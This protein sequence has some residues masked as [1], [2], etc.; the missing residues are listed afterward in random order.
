RKDAQACYLDAFGIFSRERRIDRVNKVREKLTQLDQW[1]SVEIPTTASTTLPLPIAA[2]EPITLPPAE[3]AHIPPSPF[4]KPR[5][6][7]QLPGTGTK[8]RISI[9]VVILLL[10]LAIIAAIALPL[11]LIRN[12][13]PSA[14]APTPHTFPRGIGVF[15]DEKNENIGISDGSYALDVGPD[16]AG[17]KDK[18]D[19]SAQLRAGNIGAATALWHS[20]LSQDSSDAEV[21]IYLEDQN[22]IASKQPYFTIVIGTVLSDNPVDYASRDQLQ[23][24]YVAQ[25]EYNEQAKRSGVPLL[26]LLIAKSGNN[27]T[28]SIPIAHQVVQAA[29]SDKT[30]IGVFG[31][32]KTNSSIDVLP[33]LADAH[34]P[35][36][37]SA[38]GGDDLSGRSPFFF[39][40]SPPNKVQAQVLVKYT[41][42]QL[43]P[44][45]LV[46]FV[47]P[48]DAF[49]QSFKEQRER[50]G[51]LCDSEVMT[52]LIHFHQSH[53]RHF[54][55]YYTEHVQ[56]YL[57]SEFPHLVGYPRFVA[58]P[59]T[60]FFK[61]EETVVSTILNGSTSTVT[62]SL[63]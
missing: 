25:H 33:I 13:G 6:A 22:I 38:A 27:S 59:T 50:A 4:N 28:N 7:Q 47:D 26:R 34:I 61:G 24:A 53:Y 63:S 46:V 39:R 8:R 23:G 18:A 40:V 17:S 55:A 3:T 51:Q 9:P 41:E 57:R 42:T 16:R 52:L 15:P 49:S 54:K 44:Q 21:L 2:T 31:W 11:A 56:I 20:A 35:V 30:I 10:L 48:N 36:L 60:C 29:N 1:K 32:T 58:V 43:H 5:H 12:A 45:R 37:A 19:A 14:A 62:Y